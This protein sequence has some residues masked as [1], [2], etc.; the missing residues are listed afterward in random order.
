MYFSI[1]VP[2][3]NILVAHFMEILLHYVHTASQLIFV[4]KKM[5]V[6]M[7]VIS[8]HRPLSALNSNIEK[9]CATKFQQGGL[10]EFQQFLIMLIKEHLGFRG[11]SIFEL[12]GQGQLIL[13]DKIVSG[14]RGVVSLAL[15]I[16]CN[17]HLYNYSVQI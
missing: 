13:V 5:Y 6:I 15:P 16:T 12:S 8:L 10:R 3:V 17:Q 1:I 4:L 7:C 2:L 9:P 11:V 14:W